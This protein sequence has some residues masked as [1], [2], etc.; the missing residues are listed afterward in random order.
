[1]LVALQLELPEAVWVDVDRRVRALL[2]ELEQA[3]AV[4][5]LVE[6]LRWI[7]DPSYV[8]NYGDGEALEIHRRWA[9]R[10]LAR[11]EQSLGNGE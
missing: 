7:R 2:A 9:A 6:A 11:Y 5:A 10:A 3:E 8:G 4:P 1:M